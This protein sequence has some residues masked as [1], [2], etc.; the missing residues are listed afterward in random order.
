MRPRRPLSDMSAIAPDS[1]IANYRVESLISAGGMGEVYKAIDLKLQRP[2]ALKILPPELSQSRERIRRFL[3]EAR[4]ASSL[5]HPNILTVYDAGDANGVHFIATELV[6]G[7]TLRDLIHRD[8]VPLKRIT[9]YLAQAADG[10]AKAHQAGIVHRDLKPANIMVTNDGFAKV[11]DFG[12]AK[13]TES[14][15]DQNSY[16]D[17]TRDGLILGTVAYMSPEQAQGHPVDHRSDVFAFGA[18]LY[19][20]AARRQAFSGTSDPEILHSIIHDDPP[21]LA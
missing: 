16:A 3:Q 7:N 21:P 8:R 17:R 4:A 15:T 11:L 5:N 14:Q 1:T 2:V 18:I 12:L 19:E 9:G 6:V 10:V 20:A 13:L